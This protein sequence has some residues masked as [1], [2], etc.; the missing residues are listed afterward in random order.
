MKGGM[1]LGAGRPASHVKAEHCM[2]LDVRK[3]A[4]KK[5]L[6]SGA[7]SWRWWN[8]STGETLGTIGFYGKPGALVLNYSVNGRPINEG[9]T[10]TRT[11]CT[12]GGSRPWFRC[13]RCFGRVGVLYLRGERFRC[14]KCHGLRYAS[15]SEDACGRAW[16]KQSKL[17]ARL[18]ENWRRPKGM[19]HKT[20]N[21]LLE[22]IWQCESVREDALVAYM[23]RIGFKGW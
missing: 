16:R 12:Y 5:L 20:R 21:G 23:D 4:R 18:G 2:S 17:E 7:G 11:D 13:P 9:V 3:L 19:H 22:V 10:I 15:Q 8:T 14:R 6:E 1:R